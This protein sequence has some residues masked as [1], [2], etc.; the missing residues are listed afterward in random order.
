MAISLQAFRNGEA[1][2]EYR[3]VEKQ[4]QSEQECVDHAF[5]HLRID[6]QYRFLGHHGFIIPTGKETDPMLYKGGR[7]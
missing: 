2:G 3:I 7:A 1:V 5:R 4:G 6:L